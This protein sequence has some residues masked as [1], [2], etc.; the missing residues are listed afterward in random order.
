MRDERTT[1]RRHG[2]VEEGGMSGGEQKEVKSVERSR[3]ELLS[4]A[5]TLTKTE[6]ESSFLIHF[7][8]VV[9]AERVIELKL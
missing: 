4:D 5:I 3:A 2:G 9:A 6:R 1:G 7:I 8:H